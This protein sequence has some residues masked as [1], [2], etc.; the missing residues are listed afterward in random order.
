MTLGITTLTTEANM[1]ILLVVVVVVVVAVVFFM[2]RERDFDDAKPMLNQH[3]LAAVQGTR[4][5]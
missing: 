5:T 2:N 4:A 1:E 3:L